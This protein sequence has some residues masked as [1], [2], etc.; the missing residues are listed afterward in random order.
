MPFKKPVKN[1]S[2]LMSQ[3]HRNCDSNYEIIEK[4]LEQNN[5]AMAK[6]SFEIWRDKNLK[7]FLIEEEILFLETIKAIG[8]KIPPIM[9]MELEH[10]QIRNCFLE[11]ENSLLAEDITKFYQLA[12]TCMIMIQQHNFKEE[13]ILYPIIDRA[14]LA[15]HEDVLSTVSKKLNE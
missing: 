14:I 15:T 11:I 13:Q 6:N 9:V 2:T 3:D 4:F 8:G 7:H 5:L 1:I 12:E 10:L